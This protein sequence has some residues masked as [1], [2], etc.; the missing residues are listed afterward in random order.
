MS[1]EVHAGPWQMFKSRYMPR[2]FNRLLPVKM[3]QRS[4]AVQRRVTTVAEYPGYAGIGEPGIGPHI[5]R[6]YDTPMTPYEKRR[7]A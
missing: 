6:V 1:Y 2:W 4:I 5:I 7:S 3:H